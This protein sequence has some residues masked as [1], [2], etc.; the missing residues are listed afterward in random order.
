MNKNLFLF[1]VLGAFSLGSLGA[2]ADFV[3]FPTE[4][5]SWTV[6]ITNHPSAASASAPGTAK[7]GPPPAYPTHVAVTQKGKLK[8]IQITWSD[9]K[10]TERWVISGLPV[11]FNEDPRNGQVRPIQNGSFHEKLS[12]LSFSYDT[13]A[14]NWITADS[15]QGKDPVSYQGKQCFHYLGTAG[16]AMDDFRDSQSKREAWIDS[17]TGLPVALDTGDA[18]STYT[19][20]DKPPTD[21]LVPPPAFAKEFIYYKAVLGVP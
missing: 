16:I 10:K 9:G 17:K 5:A 8:R 18:I 19:F 4:D 3:T 1:F 12:N 14:F 15:L 7:N 2:S 13:F 11:T 20:S 6:D 21:P